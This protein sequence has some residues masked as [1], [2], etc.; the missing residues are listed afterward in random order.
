[1]RH[2]TRMWLVAACCALL[3]ACSCEEEGGADAGLADGGVDAGVDAGL[4]AG[5]ADAGSDAA[6]DAGPDAG[7]APTRESSVTQ[8]AG[9]GRA[10]SASHE[11]RVGV[12]APQ[13]IGE[14]SNGTRRLRLGP[15]P[16]P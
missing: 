13:P 12:G 4:D 10:S 6:I 9:G 11:L 2:G 16:V 1:M 5:A 8:T 14:M 7:P 15:V 3:G